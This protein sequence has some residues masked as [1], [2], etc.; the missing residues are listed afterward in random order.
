MLRCPALLAGPAAVGLLLECAGMPQVALEKLWWHCAGLVTRLMAS[1]QILGS[2]G[3][4]ACPSSQ[5]Q[6]PARVLLPDG[7]D[8]PL[9]TAEVFNKTVPLAQPNRTRACC[10]VDSGRCHVR[11]EERSLE[12]LLYFLCW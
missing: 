4:G 5:L 8:R 1:E 11:K 7:C 12:R 3:S 9:E 6:S 2:D 10:C